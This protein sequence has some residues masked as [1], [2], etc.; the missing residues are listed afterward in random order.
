M[1]AYI[2]SRALSCTFR[3]NFEVS[4][5]IRLVCPPGTG[6]TLLARAVAG[7]VGVPFFS[8]SVAEFVE[9]FV[10]VGAARARDLFEQ[11][12][13]AAPC[14]IFIDELDALGRSRGPGAFAGYDEKEQTLNQLLGRARRVRSDDRRNPARRHQSTGGARSA[15]LRPGR[16]DRQ[17]LVDRPDR[18][19]RLKTLKVHVAKIRLLLFG[20][21]PIDQYQ[22]QRDFIIMRG[23]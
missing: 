14:I 19:G 20:S 16:F 15:L 1:S 4:K 9:M 17:V 12:R 21:A 18:S 8:I 6:K 3:G 22:L 11:A 13:K 7:E 2:P 5:G 23:S 10:G